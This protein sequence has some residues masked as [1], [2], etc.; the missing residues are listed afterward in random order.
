MKIVIFDGF[1]MVYDSFYLYAK[2]NKAI[3]IGGFFT[4]FDA[5]RESLSKEIP[6]VIILDI[7]HTEEHG[8][9][10]VSAIR[11]LAPLSRIVV[12]SS[13]KSSFV[14]GTCIAHGAD[15]FI[16]KQE[17]VKSIFEAIKNLKGVEETDEPKAHLL[18]LTYKEKIII[19][20]IIEGRTSQ[21]I[22]KTTKNS[23]HTINNQKNRMILKYG[24]ESSTELVYKLTRLGYIKL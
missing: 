12:Y 16:S 8:V 5:L 11:A 7:I 18:H 19:G 22:A 15:L 23:I 1:P 21:E 24:C 20:Y 6:D 13:A 14:Q 17:S 3:K 9:E 2:T 10:M 4:E